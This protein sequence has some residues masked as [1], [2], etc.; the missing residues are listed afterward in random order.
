[1]K[2]IRHILMTADTLGGVFSHAIE[3]SGALARRGVRVTLATMG[4]LLSQPQRRAAAGVPGLSIFEST[5]RLEWMDDA[6]EDVH[7]AGAWLLTLEKRLRPDI[8]HLASYAHGALPF[9][10]PKIVVAHSSVLAWF[11]AVRGEAAPARYERYRREAARGVA[12]ANAV[13]AP[14]QAAL[15]EAA[16]HHGP[17]ARGAVIPNGREG[18]RYRP[19]LPKDEMIVSLGRLW[20]KAKNIAALSAVAPNLPWPVCVAGNLHHPEDGARPLPSLH[21]KGVLS[22]RDVMALLGRAAIYAH[23]ARYEPFGLSVL[24]AALSGCALVL[25]D[26]KSLREVWGDTAALYVSPDDPGELEEA[27]LSLVR[28]PLARAEMGLRARDHALHYTPERM[29]QGYLDLYAELLAHPAPRPIEVAL[30]EPCA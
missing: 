7:R 10:A 23:P 12:A 28:S 24:E 4:G 21:H 13:V 26:L 9:R 1:M 17:I 11:E 27:L 30:E 22:P 6:W 29:A 5:Y 19:L 2:P 25:G 18:R 15:D 8:V 16:L 20:D 14:T 3:L